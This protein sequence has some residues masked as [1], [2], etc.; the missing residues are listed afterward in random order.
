MADG[1]FHRCRLPG[2]NPLEYF[3]EPDHLQHCKFASV[4]FAFFLNWS[5]SHGC[6]IVGHGGIDPIAGPGVGR[7]DAKGA[8]NGNANVPGN[9][10]F[11]ANDHNKKSSLQNF[12]RVLTV[13]S[14]MCVFSKENPC[15]LIWVATLPRS[16][17]MQMGHTIS[18]H[19]PEFQASPSSLAATWCPLSLDF[20]F[21]R[22][23]WE[24]Q[25][26]QLKLQ[27]TSNR[28]LS[29]YPTYPQIQ[30][31]RSL[32]EANRSNWFKLQNGTQIW[33]QLSRIRKLTERPLNETTDVVTDAPRQSPSIPPWLHLFRSDG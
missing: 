2:L 24:V 9:L 22:C 11:L 6:R 25:W 12:K 31:S 5:F 10:S 14:W 26:N 32:S 1:R 4:Y 30:I 33:N 3:I 8:P 20:L 15:H 21:V 19:V 7:H 27:E 16:S 17:Q 13:N 28:I 29:D 18:R 23:P